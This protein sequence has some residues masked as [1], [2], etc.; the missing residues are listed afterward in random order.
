MED[1][2]FYKNSNE[3]NSNKTNKGSDENYEED[4]NNMNELYNESQNNI[5]NNNLLNNIENQNNFINDN[6]IY[7]NNYNINE[8]NNYNY[9]N[10]INNNKQYANNF[11]INK[12]NEFNNNLENNNLKNNIIENP[13]NFNEIQRIPNIINNN[14]P[15]NQFN[16]SNILSN[17]NQN[18]MP[19]PYI[20]NNKFQYNNQ[21]YISPMNESQSFLN[22]SLLNNQLYFYIERSNS[23]INLISRLYEENQE[24]RFNI[25]VQAQNNHLNNP[26]IN[27][28][29]NNNFNFQNMNNINNPYIQ[30][31][32]L[33]N[34]FKYMNNNIN[35]SHLQKQ[36]FNNNNFDYQNINNINKSYIRNQSI[37]NNN[38]FNSPNMNNI[39]NPYIQKKNFNNNFNYNYK[40]INMNNKFQNNLFKNINNNYN[41]QHNNTNKSYMNNN[42][43]NSFIQK[44]NLKNI[45]INTNDYIQKKNIK[46]NNNDK[47]ASYFHGLYLIKEQNLNNIDLNKLDIKNEIINK[48]KMNNYQTTEE[49]NKIL[50]AFDNKKLENK[51]YLNE[52]MFLSIDKISIYTPHIIKNTNN[53]K[54]ILL[55]KEEKE[56]KLSDF[57]YLETHKEINNDIFLEILKNRIKQ[58]NNYKD[59]LNGEIKDNEYNDKIFGFNIS[60]NTLNYYLYSIIDEETIENKLKEINILKL[61][62]DLLAS[63]SQIDQNTYNNSQSH[64]SLN[65]FNKNMN[66]LHGL[67][68]EGL[69]LY[70]ILDRLNEK[71]YEI[72]PRILFYEYIINIKGQKLSKTEDIKSGY[73]EFDYAILSKCNYK[74]NNEN[75]LL[76][77]QKF[78]N[79]LNNINIKDNIEFEIKKNVIY[80]FELKSSDEYINDEY[81]DLLFYKYYEFIK[82]YE[83]KKWVTEE[84][85]KEIMLIYDY[86]RTDK[87]YNKYKEKIE[88][89]I[90]KNKNCSFNIVY[91]LR[92]YPYFSHSLAI[93]KY[94]N[95]KEEIKN[96]NDKINK[97]QEENQKLKNE[98][99]DI[100]NKNNDKIN[101]LQEENQK[102]KNEIG[103]IENKNNDKINKLQEENQ[104]LKNEIGDILEENQ[105]LKN[106]IGDIKN[107]NNILLE[108][109]Q[110]LKNEINALNN[111]L[112]NENSN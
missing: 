85:K 4:G 88:D 102:L 80:L 73:M 78:E 46:Y 90:K 30:K 48:I 100:E 54:S 74:Y 81:F 51:I 66:Y 87:I 1:N 89:F 33:N 37:N 47:N 57:Q 63:K 8:P 29:F 39:S 42:I 96:N 11:N 7:P 41:S 110:K 108:E 19:Y 70:I 34:N 28:N 112:K 18:N 72:L 2:Y 20:N 58:F 13:N 56:L 26:Y 77:Q 53:L 31:E 21:S 43:N 38:N 75:P 16:Y 92:S 60:I 6:I 25:N 69:I 12:F 3:V 93:N 98:I 76:V 65:I 97:L 107:K 62:R 104:K 5:E 67:T 94:N 91:S 106:E 79:N 9:N 50:N 24:L 103:D 15:Q 61:K 36:D 82:L 17:L 23:L 59:K 52:Y 68:Y 32:N 83:S 55:P 10:L 35:N 40:N 84:T 27:R 45:E 101:K 109:I 111:K 86:K 14:Q 22:N 64:K 95:L 44:K 105:K 71:E 99:G 49:D